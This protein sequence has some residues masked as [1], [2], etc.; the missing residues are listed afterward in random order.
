[1]AFVKGLEREQTIL[2]P[3]AVDDFFCRES[4]TRAV[5]A[6]VDSL[7]LA[8]LGFHIRDDLAQGRTS[9]HPATLLKLYLWGYLNR[10]RSSRQLEEASRSN[11][12]VIWLTGN[13]RPDHSTISRFRKGQA[14]ALA[15]IFSHFTTICLQLGLFGRELVAVDGTFIKAVNSRTRSYT[16]EQLK[17]LVEKIDRAAQHYLAQLEALDAREDQSETGSQREEFSAKLESIRQNQGKFETLFKESEENQSGQVNLT[18]PDSRQLR[19]RG[20][21]TIGY[22]VQTAVD[23]KHHLVVA[24]EVTQDGNDLGQLDPMIQKAKENLGLDPESRI[25]GLADTGYHC[26]AQLA[27]CKEHNSE[28]YVP[29]PDRRTSK[30]EVYKV[31]DFIHQPALAHGDPRSDSYRCPNGE[32]LTRRKDDVRKNGQAYHVYG[33]KVGSCCGCPL[34]KSC[35]K[36]AARELR[37][38]VHQ[39]VIDE[40]RIRLAANPDTTRKRGSLVEPPFGTF[41]DHTGSRHLL[42]KGIPNVRAEVNSTFWSYNF[43]RVLEIIGVGA[44]IEVFTEAEVGIEAV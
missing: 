42:T 8:A 27:A 3:P 35:T 44:L 34:K 16:K 6:F 2:L 32:T 4:P 12:N 21:T 14:P 38:S 9:Y 7:D 20:Q 33:A 11:L 28:V 22:N 25:D 13:L 10:T 23:D 17:K 39:E 19:K 5:D 18:D 26:G 24:C 37:V 41:K 40:A 29:S 30:A 1:M 36:K 43:K 15:K 31:S